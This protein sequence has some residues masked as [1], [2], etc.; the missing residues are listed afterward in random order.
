M[1]YNKKQRNMNTLKNF[2][3]NQAEELLQQ[4]DLA[5]LTGGVSDGDGSDKINALADCRTTNNC[6]GG[7]C[8]TQCS[9]NKEETGER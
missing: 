7:N 4:S 2:I 6:H 5:S 8:V 3:D 1:E 9:C